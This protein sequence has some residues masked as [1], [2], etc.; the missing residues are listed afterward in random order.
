MVGVASVDF[1]V[2]GAWAA[3]EDKVWDGR[4]RE[5]DVVVPSGVSV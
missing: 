5:W 1:E 2:P 4:G 3:G